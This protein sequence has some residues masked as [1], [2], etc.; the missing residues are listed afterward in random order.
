MTRIN[1]KNLKGNERQY[2]NI[3]R[4]GRT[5]NQIFLSAPTYALLTP[6]QAITLAT[7]LLDLIEESRQLPTQKTGEPK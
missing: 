3:K 1:V 7:A 5:P 6:D 4:D 2:I